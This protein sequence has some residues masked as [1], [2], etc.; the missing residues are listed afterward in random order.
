MELFNPDLYALVD[1]L[2]SCFIV[3]LRKELKET[4]TEKNKHITG[5][6]IIGGPSGRPDTKYLL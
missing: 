1:C 3:F 4:A 6:S 5:K 2:R